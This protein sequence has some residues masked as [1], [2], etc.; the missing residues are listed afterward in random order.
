M[1]E[2]E[3][4]STITY[5]L[6]VR[7]INLLY[8]YKRYTCNKSQSPPKN[9]SNSLHTVVTLN[10]MFSLEFYFNYLQHHKPQMKNSQMFSAS[11]DLC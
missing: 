4:R 5:G 10:V 6:R 1:W 3:V 8:F 2:E 7:L 9:T 11:R